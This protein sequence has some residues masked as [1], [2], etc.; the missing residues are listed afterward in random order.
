MRRIVKIFIASS[1]ENSDVAHTVGDIL[2]KSKSR[3]FKIVSVPWDQGTFKL[4]KTYIESLEKELDN[5]DFSILILTPNDITR[6]RGEEVRTPRD[7]V[8]FELGLFMGRLQRERCFMLFERDDEPK[9]PTDLLGVGAATYQ[10]SNLA[11]LQKALRPACKEILTRVLEILKEQKLCSFVYEIEGKWWM[12]IETTVGV[13]LSFFDIYSIE[14]YSS[15]S[16]KGDHF[17]EKGELIGS[18]KSVMVGILEAQHKLF[19]QWEGDS[20]P[21][22]DNDTLYLQGYGTLEFEYTKEP[23]AKGKGFFID[24][25]LNNAK[26][27]VQRKLFRFRRITNLGHIRTMTDGPLV[28][29]KAVVSQVFEEW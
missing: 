2:G 5:V 25:D 26:R 21:N 13:E 8:L 20:L 7:N 19:Y 6:I 14:K 28:A 29:K 11:G 12:R 4:S 22:K 27:T 16:M 17:R 9:L 24:L 18:W 23:P 10:K 1:S 15:V 3:I